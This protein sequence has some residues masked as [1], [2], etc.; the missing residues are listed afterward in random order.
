MTV[1]QAAVRVTGARL[2][3]HLG[4]AS[5]GDRSRVGGLMAWCLERS[6][7]VASL[8]RGMVAWVSLAGC[9]YSVTGV[10]S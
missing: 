5:D 7:E 4:M 9:A 2:G 3:G 6:F 8:A 10:T 1:S